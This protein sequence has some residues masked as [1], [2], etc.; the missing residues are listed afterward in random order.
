MD[1]VLIVDTASDAF[2]G[3]FVTGTVRNSRFVRIGADGVDVSGS[4]IT[5]RDTQFR[6][7]GDK[8]MSIGEHSE[9]K[10]YNIVVDNAKMGAAA[11]DLSKVTIR[12]ARISNTHVAGFAAYEKK[13]EYGP[14]T[15]SAD[16]VIFNNAKPQA[17]VQEGSSMTVNG[18]KVKSK[19]LDVKTM[20]RLGI[21]G[22]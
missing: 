19:K 5:V 6:Q 7:L 4:R 21:L 2:D 8:G 10:A 13:A 18:E 12:T 1:D 15:L 11:K 16:G 3:D 20:Y 9:A 17:L 22:T 14:G